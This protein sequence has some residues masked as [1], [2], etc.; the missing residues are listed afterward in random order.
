LFYCCGTIKV[1]LS[2]CIHTASSSFVVTFV[3]VLIQFNLNWNPTDLKVERHLINLGVECF[4]LST[5][6]PNPLQCNV[7]RVVSCVVLPV[8]HLSS[9]STWMCWYVV[10]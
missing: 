9:A 1:S 2:T 5:V 10:N 8:C 3:T 7:R 6:P 4:D